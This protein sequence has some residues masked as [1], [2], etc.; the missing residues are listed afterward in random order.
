MYFK[1]RNLTIFFILFST[2][3]F[4]QTVTTKFILSG[5]LVDKPERKSNTTC[6]FKKKKEVKII[7][8]VNER[9]WKVDYKGC[10]G[11]VTSP[12]LLITDEL[13]EFKENIQNNIQKDIQIE[14][15]HKNDSI[16]KGIFNNKKRTEI[17]KK[18]I[19]KSTKDSL[20]K[21]KIR[22][23][24]RVK[25]EPSILGK[26]KF[27][28]SKNDSIVVLDYVDNYFKVCI[29]SKCG[30]VNEMYIFSGD[31]EQDDL[32]RE[33]KRVKTIQK[34]ELIRKQTKLVEEEK[35]RE[36][37]REKYKYHNECTY[38]LK[39][40]DEFTGILRKNTILYDLDGYGV[41]NGELKIQLRRYGSSKY[42]RI[43]SFHDLGCTS[44]YSSN[45]STVKFKLENGDIVT[46]YHSD[47]I[48]C[49]NFD[50]LGKLTQNDIIRLKKSPI[51]TV[52]LSGTDYYHDFK[53]VKWNNFFI[54]KLD[55]IK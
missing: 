10:V 48:D 2:F 7:D 54:D 11:Y 17:I 4:S 45:K 6:E 20:L 36:R 46:F 23:F 43:K 29:D 34:N 35:L 22:R 8:F 33:L 44:S 27:F 42:I 39:E 1:T 32:V 30:Y 55:C 51:K 3:L 5:Y 16:Q 47:D 19:L 26:D 9:W 15:N 37:E 52:R 13:I 50:L 49:G 28:I 38:D 41:Y 24:L 14:N 25:S 12:Y 53:S 40:V 21:I 31:K 18:D